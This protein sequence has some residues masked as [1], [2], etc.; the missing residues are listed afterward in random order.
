[1]VTRESV[2]TELTGGSINGVHDHRRHVERKKE[3]QSR[4]EGF[5][6]R[7]PDE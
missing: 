5:N 6:K 2:L 4:L 3:Y 7:F 1:M